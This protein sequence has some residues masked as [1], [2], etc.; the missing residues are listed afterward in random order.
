[1]FAS[2]AQAAAAY[3]LADNYNHT[4][5]FSAFE[6]FEDEDPT[7]GFVNYVDA[8][9]A[10]REG[11]AGY[12]NGGIYLGTDYTNKTTTGRHSVRLTSK[13]T[14]TQGLFVADIA[15]MPAGPTDAGSCGIWPAY[16]TLG[17]NW[18]NGGE[19]DI[20]EGVNE[21]DTNAVTLHTAEG[22]TITNTGSIA[23]TKLGNGDC[24]GNIGCKQTTTGENNYGARFNKAQ[25]GIYV[26]EWAD[27]HISAWFFSRSAEIP[28]QLMT[29]GSGTGG[30]GTTA[31][32][33]TIDTASFGQ[34]LAKF[35]G[36]PGCSISEHFKEHAIVINTSFCGQWAG[37]VWSDSETCSALGDSC[38]AYV[39]ENPEAF[40]DAYWLFNSIRVYQQA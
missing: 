20:L 38:D 17:P 29:T 6:F 33:T 1:V 37:K 40:S 32:P 10:S 36:G 23:S 28:P 16:W 21:Q 27:D 13:K 14:W 26:I 7:Q 25:G 30:N 39:G 8:E 3:A 11:L 4:N 31:A 18:P 12:T 24:Y 15:H 9:T 5:F 34:P 35:V 19:I 2:S 22:C